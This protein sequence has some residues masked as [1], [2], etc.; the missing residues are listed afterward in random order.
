[1]RLSARR[2]NH[3]R[4]PLL[5]PPNPPDPHPR[6]PGGSHRPRLPHRAAEDGR[7]RAH[8]HRRHPAPRTRTR[9][10]AHA[11]VIKAGTSSPSYSAHAHL[12]NSDRWATAGC[13][14]G[15]SLPPVRGPS[16]IPAQAAQA[17]Q[18]GSAVEPAGSAGIDRITASRARQWRAVS[19]AAHARPVRPVRSGT[20]RAPHRRGPSPGRRGPAASGCPSPASRRRVR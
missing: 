7:K 13:L 4:H 1:M 14:P 16:F 20:V 9:V 6:R 17:A 11:K 10:T 19:R 5:H 8:R 3:P 12:G 2:R 18:V 15:P